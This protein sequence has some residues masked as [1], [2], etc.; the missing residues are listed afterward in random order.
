[1]VRELA[2][3]QGN[4][5]V[6]LFLVALVA[7]MDGKEGMSERFYIRGQFI[8]VVTLAAVDGMISSSLQRSEVLSDTV[9]IHF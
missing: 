3:L 4:F 8:S 6:Y 7:A 9:V 1:M 2:N 5:T